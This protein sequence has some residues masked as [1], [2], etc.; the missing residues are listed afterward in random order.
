M[1]DC[2]CCNQIIMKISVESL[3]KDG[4]S[5]CVSTSHIMMVYFTWEH[6]NIVSHFIVMLNEEAKISFS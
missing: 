5:E 6:T 1:N 3:V 4:M 2:E